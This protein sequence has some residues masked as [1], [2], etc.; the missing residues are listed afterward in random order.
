MSLA[1]PCQKHI[2]TIK[3]IKFIFGILAATFSFLF[4]FALEYSLNR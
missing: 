1:V 3:R 2:E 4:S